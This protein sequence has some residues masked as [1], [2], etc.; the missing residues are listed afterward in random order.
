[1]TNSF[2]HSNHV[3]LLMPPSTPSGRSCGAIAID[4]AIEASIQGEPPVI[5]GPQGQVL[6]CLFW[7]FYGSPQWTRCNEAGGLRR[8]W[9]R[10]TEF[11]MCHRRPCWEMCFGS[12]YSLDTGA[13][14]RARYLAGR[15]QPSTI[16]GGTCEVVQ[17]TGEEITSLLLRLIT[18]QNAAYSLTTLVFRIGT[19]DER[20]REVRIAGRRALGLE[21]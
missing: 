12:H 7:G 1:M 4:C 20:E 17:A 16:I 3:S 2:F 13:R 10:L 5:L 11:L 9:E 21:G 14:N 18:L 15:G 8:C 6:Q 19:R